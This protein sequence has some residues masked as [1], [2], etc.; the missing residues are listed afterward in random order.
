[1]IDSE[2]YD[3]HCVGPRH[4]VSQRWSVALWACLLRLHHSWLECRIRSTFV[5]WIWCI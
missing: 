3:F 2:R 5:V 1:M 4:G